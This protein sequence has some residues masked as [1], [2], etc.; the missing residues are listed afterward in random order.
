MH[1]SESQ[2]HSRERR[3]QRLERASDKLRLTRA[4]AGGGRS[5]EVEELWEEW[6]GCGVC[7]GCCRRKALW[8][9]VVNEVGVAWVV[10]QGVVRGQQRIQDTKSTHR[11]GGVG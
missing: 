9:E 2:S 5:D 3:S 10:V 11:S 8:A 6:M 4:M 1:W 7:E